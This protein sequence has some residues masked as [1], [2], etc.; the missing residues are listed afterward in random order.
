MS[1]KN[2]NKQNEC[3]CTEKYEVSFEEKK[4]K[5][6]PSKPCD[7]TNPDYPWVSCGI[8]KKTKDNEEK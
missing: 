2:L 6:D 1:N 3:N 4:A 5:V 8:D 7:P